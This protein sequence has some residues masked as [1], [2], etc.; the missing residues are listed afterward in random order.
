[1]NQRDQITRQTKLV[2]TCTAI[3]SSAMPKWFFRRLLVCRAM[4][5]SSLLRR[6]LPNHLNKVFHPTR[7]A[8]GEGESVSRNGRPSPPCSRMH[9]VN[10]LASRSTFPLWQRRRRYHDIGPARRSPST[11]NGPVPAAQFGGFSGVHLR[12]RDL[13]L[14]PAAP[15]TRARQIGCGWLGPH[16]HDTAE[17]IGT[18][19]RAL[20]RK[21]SPS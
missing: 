6:S 15:A 20:R 4:R 12:G 13:F 1:M 16:G 19:R 14:Q 17:V 9:T 2:Q 7:V 18:V 11:M 3:R 8:Q 5:S 21:K 10:P